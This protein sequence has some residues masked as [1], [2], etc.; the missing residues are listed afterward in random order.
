MTN[1]NKTVLTDKMYVR[2]PLHTDWRKRN[3]L[4]KIWIDTHDVYFFIV[5][6]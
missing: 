5:A 2:A 6:N 1:M 4:G 3:L